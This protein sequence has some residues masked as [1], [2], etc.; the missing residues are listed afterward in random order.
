MGSTG[1][2]GFGSFT[3]EVQRSCETDVVSVEGCPGVGVG[4]ES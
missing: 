3:S 4:D 1:L 2:E